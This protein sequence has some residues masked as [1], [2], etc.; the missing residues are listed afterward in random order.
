MK[1]VYFV[2]H[3]ESE[4][5]AR[6]ILTGQLDLPLTLAGE[7]AAREA[8]KHWQRIRPQV[9]Y[10]SALRRAQQTGRLLFPNA[11]IR[12]DSR[13]NER[14]FGAW[15]GRAKA[16]L[17]RLHPEA[18]LRN[19]RLAPDYTPPSGEPLADLQ[20]R[21]QSFLSG[22]ASAPEETVA[23]V[24]H[25][26]IFAFLTR[27]LP[28][29]QPAQLVPSGSPSSFL[30]Y[31]WRSLSRPILP[32]MLEALLVQGYPVTSPKK[33]YQTIGL[34]WSEKKRLRLPPVFGPGLRWNL[35]P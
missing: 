21:L 10:C 22:V 6:G 35:R 18:F 5:N 28:F 17:Q 20:A 32:G 11:S 14:H 30:L 34:S 15:H 25:A 8:S 1:T 2:R 3:A 19:G 4:G 24:T 13:L 29:N 16:D 27:E 7:A 26:G 23:C 9:V 31:V 12:I 33:A